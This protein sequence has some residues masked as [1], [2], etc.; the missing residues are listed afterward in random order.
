[1]NNSDYGVEDRH[2]RQRGHYYWLSA[3][4]ADNKTAYGYISKCG[5]FAELTLDVTSVHL[6]VVTNLDP[7]SIALVSAVDGK[8]SNQ[9][10]NKALKPVL[11]NSALYE[12]KIT[13]KD[14]AQNITID[15]VQIGD[16]VTFD[17]KVNGEANR[18]SAI[19]VDQDGKE[20]MYYGHLVDISEQKVGQASVSLPEDFSDKKYKLMVFSEKY[21][22][23][24]TTDY[25]SEFIEVKI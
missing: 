14:V 6:R 18:L 2:Y 9:I 17:Y 5:V 11:E 1:M 21:H 25:A 24:S 19:I 23:G 8:D 16:D 20:I 7:K 22:E 10:G 3:G 4:S 13:L 15:N 12:Y